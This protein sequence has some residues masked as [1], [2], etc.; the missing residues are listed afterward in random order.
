MCLRT[1]PGPTVRSESGGP[2]PPEWPE[3]IVMCAI[4][5]PTGP[6]CCQPGAQ[7]LYARFASSR[8]SVGQSATALRASDSSRAGT[9]P[10]AMTG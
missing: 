9:G 3:V 6:W 4:D 7:V 2:Q 8:A 5:G 10:G 1:Y